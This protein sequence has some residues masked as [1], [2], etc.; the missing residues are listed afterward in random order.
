MFVCTHTLGHQWKAAFGAAPQWVKTVMD[1]GGRLANWCTANP[2]VFSGFY[3]PV[4]AFTVAGLHALPPYLYILG[5]LPPSLH[6]VSP[7]LLYAPAVILAAGRVL[8]LAVEVSCCLKLVQLVF[9][10]ESGGRI[11]YLGELLVGVMEDNGCSITTKALGGVCYVC[12]LA[13][14]LLRI[15]LS[16]WQPLHSSCM[17]M[18]LTIYRPSILL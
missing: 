15:T 8:A 10:G 12:L 7:I 3:T 17:H 5:H 6:N 14:Q 18:F 4:G 11:M 9:L 13:C 2:H 16:L 1:N